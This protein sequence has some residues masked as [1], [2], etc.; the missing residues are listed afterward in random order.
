MAVSS[1]CSGARMSDGLPRSEGP[2]GTLVATSPLDVFRATPMQRVQLLRDGLSARDAKSILADLQIPESQAFKAINVS[3]AAV[4]RRA[5]RN[6]PLAVPEAERVLG[7]AKLIGQVQQMVDQSG[8]P[9][10]F[11]ASAWLSGWL[12]EPMPAFG[13]TRPLELLDT[14]EGQSLVAITLGQMQSGAYA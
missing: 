8:N 13:G 2:P 12:I 7:V 3:R 4:I 14:M 5:R 1:R 11:S 6:E 10:G 9:E